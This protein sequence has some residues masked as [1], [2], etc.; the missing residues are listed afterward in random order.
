MVIEVKAQGTG[1]V[2]MLGIVVI[3]KMQVSYD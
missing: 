1:L 2:S 3:G